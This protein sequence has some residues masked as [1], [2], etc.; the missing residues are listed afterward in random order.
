MATDWPQVAL[1]DLLLESRPGYWGEAEPSDDRPH[2]AQVVRNCD[3]G[4]SGKRIDSVRRFLSTKERERSQLAIGDI[5]I[6]TSGEVGKTWLANEP[7]YHATNFVR[8][9][10]VNDTLCLPH[11]LRAFLASPKA[12][13]AIAAHSGGNAITNLLKSFYTST[14]VPLPPL[15]VQRRIA[16]LLGSLDSYIDALQAQIEAIRE[17]RA[18][19]AFNSLASHRQHATAALGDVASLVAERCDPMELPLTP[20]IS[21][22]HIESGSYQLAQH[23]SSADTTSLATP[24][25]AG[26]TLFGRLRPNL[27]KGGLATFSGICTTEILVLRTK[28]DVIPG[29][30]GL[31]VLNDGVFARCAQLSAGSRMPRVSTRDLLSLPTPVPPRD[32]QV[33]IVELIG[34]VDRRVTALLRQLGLAGRLRAGLLTDLLSGAHEIPQSYSETFGL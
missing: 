24:F 26:D 31:T 28:G 18:S 29:Y 3:I 8:K 11:H 21:L 6:T 32:E 14:M 33:K 30:L 9:L 5:A 27:R 34:A 7:G 10:V 15:V 22:E 20:Y 4:R 1:A 19:V 16:D 17:S 25:E 23:G 12:E 2:P 13:A